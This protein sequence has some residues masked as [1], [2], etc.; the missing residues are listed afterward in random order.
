MWVGE[1]LGPQRARMHEP[2][3]LM[4]ALLRD[5]RSRGGAERRRSAG[6]SRSAVARACAY[7]CACAFACGL[8]RRHVCVYTCVCT[9]VHVCIPFFECACMPVFMYVCMYVFLCLRMHMCVYRCVVV[10]IRVC[11]YVWM[12]TCMHDVFVCVCVHASC[13]YCFTFA[14]WYATKACMGAAKLMTGWVCTLVCRS[15]R[16][17][18]CGVWLLSNDGLCMTSKLHAGA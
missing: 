15:E 10:C 9:C 14:C 12:H 18:V 11:L 8:R 13:M 1:C 16:L 5:R 17:C 4:D 3:V 2:V 7:A 6:G